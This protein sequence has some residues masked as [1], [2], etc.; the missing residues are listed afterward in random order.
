MTTPMWR[1]ELNGTFAAD[2]DDFSMHVRRRANGKQVRFVVFKRCGADLDG[3]V[4]SGVRGDIGAAMIAAESSIKRL[5]AIAR[6]HSLLVLVVSGD[7]VVRGAIADVV[8]SAGYDTIETSSAEGALRR[9]E[10]ASRPILL[11][12]RVL[13][14]DGVDGQEFA[15]AAREVR[16]SIDVLFVTDN[17]RCYCCLPGQD[18]LIEPFSAE[19]LLRRAS[20]VNARLQAA[21]P[22]EGIPSASRQRTSW[23]KAGLRQVLGGGHER[24]L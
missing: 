14:E 13:T 2:T 7:E 6:R 18:F 8:R 24:K 12:Y 5:S 22:I 10:H 15:A 16:P 9:L 3:L 11:I 19:Q 4:D 1:E 21:T 17:I 20:I 23:F